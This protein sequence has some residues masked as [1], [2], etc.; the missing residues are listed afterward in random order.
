MRAASL[1]AIKGGISRLR[2]KGGAG[3]DTLYD[4]VNARVASDGG[5][6]PRPGNT[7]FATLPATTHGLTAFNGK[8][9][10]FSITVQTLTLP[11]VNLVVAHPTD[12]TQDIKKIH[13]AQPFLGFI[14]VVIEWNDGSIFHYWL[15][16]GGVWTAN[17]IYK[18]GDIV[19]PTVANGLAYQAVRLTSANG[20]W[21]PNTPEST[22]TQNV[23]ATNASPCVFTAATTALPDRTL[24]FLGGTAV[25]TGFTAGTFYYVVNSSA[26]TFQ[27]SLT[28]GGAAIN[29]TS[30]GTAVKVSAPDIIEPT[31]YNGFEYV[32]TSTSGAN[33]HTGTTEP[34]WPI[35]SGAVTNED[36]DAALSGSPTV[37]PNPENTVPSGVTDRY[38]SGVAASP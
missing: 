16:S 32:L 36:A 8:I 14:Y 21:T 1:T 25:P 3:A 9:Y 33:P 2:L 7:R 18:I 17:T 23:T 31:T 38:G 20:P 12:S 19:E 29:S 5:V 4:L 28:P 10:V 37:T 27:L 22:N 6:G 35:A 34:V 11:F 13:F 24:V 15:R 30:T 26:L